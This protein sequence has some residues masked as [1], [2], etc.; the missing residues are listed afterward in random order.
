MKKAILRIRLSYISQIQNGL[1][2]RIVKNK[3]D[4]QVQN[5]RPS[6]ESNLTSLYFYSD[7]LSTILALGHGD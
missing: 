7:T 2:I 4:R 3:G 1:I 6:R 5:F